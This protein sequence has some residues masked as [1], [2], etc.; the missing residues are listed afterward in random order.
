MLG[1]GGLHRHRRVPPRIHV[2]GLVGGILLQINY[3]K[4]KT[5]V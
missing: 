4:E 5:N 1:M 2:R 3:L